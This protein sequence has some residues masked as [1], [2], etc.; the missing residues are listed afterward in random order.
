M[1]ASCVGTNETELIRVSTP[2]LH[3]A[4]A[5]VCHVLRDANKY[6]FSKMAAQRQ[7]QV[8]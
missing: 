6:V 8:H 4:R 7:V 1:H 3:E 2:Y 5:A